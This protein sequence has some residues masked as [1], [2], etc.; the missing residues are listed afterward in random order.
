M[1]CRT[2]TLRGEVPCHGTEG[3]SGGSEEEHDDCRM[4]MLDGLSIECGTG[5]CGRDY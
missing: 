3:W 4:T 5:A 1:C 2:D